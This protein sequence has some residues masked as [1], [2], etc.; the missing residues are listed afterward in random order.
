MKHVFYD[1]PKY[2]FETIWLPLPIENVSIFYS[3]DNN[4]ILN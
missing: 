4:I 2:I 3:A 1:V